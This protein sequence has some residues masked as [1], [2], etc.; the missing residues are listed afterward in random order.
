MDVL[1]FDNAVSAYNNLEA[2]QSEKQQQLKDLVETYRQGAEQALLPA[3]E[4]YQRGKGLYNK[5]SSTAENVASKAEDA[6]TEGESAL[7]SAVEG[8]RGVASE[9]LNSLTES[10]MSGVTSRLGQFSSS[11]RGIGNQLSE[12]MRTNAFERDPEAELASGE[13]NMGILDRAQSL[14]RGGVSEASQ[15]VESTMSGVRGGISDAIS[16]ATEA[17]QGA[18]SG[19]TEAVSSAAESVGTAVA[20]GVGSFVAD[21]IPVV[22]QLGMLGLGIYDFVKSVTEKAPVVQAFATP[23]FEKGV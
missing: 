19:A 6:V 23:I 18:V 4:L 12:R 16:G 14:F 5:L 17:A 1:N 22:G 15:G 20:E 7:S 21:A 11:V 10:A 13:D 3:I 9:T 8:A 2:F